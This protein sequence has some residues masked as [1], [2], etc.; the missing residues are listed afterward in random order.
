MPAVI[1]IVVIAV[2][3]WFAMKSAAPETMAEFS[4][5]LQ[6]VFREI[7]IAIVHFFQ[8]AFTADTLGSMTFWMLDLFAKALST[9]LPN[10]VLNYV[11]SFNTWMTTGTGASFLRVA[12]SILGYMVQTN[13]LVMCILTGL[14]I[15]PLCGIIRVSVWVYHQFWGAS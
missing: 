12:F 8:N 9:V 10:E 15:T 13:I 14:F 7:G 1:A 4:L 6:G 5:W 11:E 3:G 2:A